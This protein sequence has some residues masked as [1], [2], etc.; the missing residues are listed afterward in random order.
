MPLGGL[1]F[2]KSGRRGRGKTSHL[3]N[4]LNY[5]FTTAR[6]SQV[7]LLSENGES[8]KRATKVQDRPGPLDECH[9]YDCWCH[10][11]ISTFE[12]QM[13]TRSLSPFP[14]SFPLLSSISLPTQFLLNS[15][16]KI[17]CVTAKFKLSMKRF[18]GFRTT[19]K[20]SRKWDTIEKLW[21]MR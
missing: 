9:Y 19:R 5:H 11:F 20:E 8:R 15:P 2:A 4:C 13:F 1:W 16:W 14:I 17:Y 12:Y 18:A 21:S 7:L 6:P 10:Q 3:V